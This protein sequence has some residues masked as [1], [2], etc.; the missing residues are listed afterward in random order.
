LYDIMYEKGRIKLFKPG[1]IVLQCHIRSALNKE[2]R[3]S[4]DKEYCSHMRAEV[5]SN[6]NKMG[7]V[8]GDLITSSALGNF[9]AM[10][11]MA[12]KQRALEGKQDFAS[13]AKMPRAKKVGNPPES[14]IGSLVL[15][16]EG[17]CKVINNDFEVF[18]LRP[19]NHFGASDVLR[20]PD[21]EY[22]GD[23]VAGP[24]GVKVMVIPK[25]DQVL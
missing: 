16:L 17:S 12:V 10:V 24:K 15:I 4:Y 13:M 6:H 14:S 1:Q 7:L 11:N 2:G 5:N 9:F 21:I 23:I 20:T 3:L 22:L 19:G 8:E 18:E 25:P